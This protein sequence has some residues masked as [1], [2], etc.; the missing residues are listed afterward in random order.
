MRDN[1]HRQPSSWVARARGLTRAWLGALAAAVL[2]LAA[3]A[4][5][6]AAERLDWDDGYPGSHNWAQ[7]PNWDPYSKPGTDDDVY[8]NDTDDYWVEAKGQYR[9]ENKCRTMTLG[10]HAG[11]VGQVL[12]NNHDSHSGSFYTY[13][14]ISQGAVIGK[15]GVGRLHVDYG[16]CVNVGSGS[17]DFIVGQ[18]A[19]SDGSVW[20][21][22]SRGAS[23]WDSPAYPYFGWNNDTVVVGDAGTGVIRLSDNARADT[24]ALILGRDARG[25][26]TVR[27]DGSS[28]VWRTSGP[29][30]IGDWGYGAL[31]VDGGDFSS[32]SVSDTHMGLHSGAEGYLSVS[33]SGALFETQDL[34]VGCEGSGSVSAYSGGLVDADNI[35]VGQ[36]GP[37]S[38]LV[39]NA[40]QVAAQSL[41]IGIGPLHPD[42]AGA[43]WS[44]AIQANPGSTINVHDFD[45]AVEAGSTA[46]ADLNGT[47]NVSGQARIG[48]AG[49]ANDVRLSGQMTFAN[50]LYLGYEATGQADCDLLNA[51]ITAPNIHIGYQG[52]AS[53]K[54]RDYFGPSTL[55]TSTVYLGKEAGS[56]G[57]LDCRNVAIAPTFALVV[58]DSG[59]GEFMQNDSDIT[60]SQPVTIAAQA[61]SSGTYQSYAN[62]SCAFSAPS[63][64]VGGGGTGSFE[65]ERGNAGATVTTTLTGDLVLGEQA[66]STGSMDIK[67]GALSVGGD[68]HVGQSGEG[69]LRLYAHTTTTVGGALNVAT[70]AG[71][72]GEVDHFSGTLTAPTLHVGAGGTGAY[73][74]S[75]GYG[76]ATFD[77]VRVGL[78]SGSS[79][80]VTQND[81]RFTANGSFHIGSDAGSTGR[82]DLVPQFASLRRDPWL[83]LND[84]AVVGYEGDGTLHQESGTV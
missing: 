50:D 27:C 77:T 75:W 55:N 69:L 21:R 23:G 51:Q 33:G 40:G 79:G 68:A 64:V 14:E 71:S 43:L 4:G 2:V 56:N 42:Y 38:V 12:S 3:A 66:G 20:V 34:F 31:Q 76:Y 44:G 32:G 41:Q 78:S 60:F 45:V 57:T 80:I 13:M 6:V 46:R 52:S 59:H 24:G 81:G 28:T 53:V 30:T 84:A 29:V 48:V 63:L 19:G 49:N 11:D 16:K 73:T 26:G 9:T 54:W 83:T 72:S 70:N 74:M 10:E 8:I 17:H 36:S 82:Y 65:Q 18:N 22:N 15:A 35:L 62:A 61:G 58:G 47:L 5:P 25:A 37:G 7:S 1:R 39:G 67:H